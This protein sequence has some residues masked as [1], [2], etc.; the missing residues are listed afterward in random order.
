M[1]KMY[2]ETKQEVDV[3]A[4]NL[5][6]Y[7][8]VLE[9]E[10]VDRIIAEARDILKRLGFRLANA[11]AAALLASAGA[12]WE[13][14]RR[15]VYLNDRLLDDALQA[16]P[17]EI[18]LYDRSGQEAVLLGGERVCFDPGSAALNILD[19]DSR[20]VRPAVSR[21]TIRLTRLVDGLEHL[22]A[23]ST[24]L[25]CSDVPLKMQD[26]YRLYLALLYSAK[27]V[28]TGTFHKDSF[29]LMRH[30]LETV[31]GGGA[32]LAKKPLA[33]F[34]ACPSPP[35]TWSDLT[36]QS[37]LDAARAGIPSELVSMPLTGANAP[38]TLLGAVVQHTAES[39]SG[40][41]ISQLARPG[42]PLIWGGSPAAFDLRRGTTPMGSI[43]TML[44][45]LA[46][47]R[48]GKRL[49]LPTHAY[50]G[51]SDAKLLDAQAGLESAL[52]TVLAGLG[53][54]NMV[55]GA[56]MLNFESTQSLEKL[57]IDNEICGMTYKMLEGLKVRDTPL[58]GDLLT[59]LEAEGHLLTH[60]HTLRWMRE[61]HYAP[62]VVID[63]DNQQEW[64]AAGS[65][66]AGERAKRR[67][68]ELIARHPGITLAAEQ[69]AAL[70]ELMAAEGRR[71][72]L[73]ALPAREV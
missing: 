39:L 46:C 5:R 56:G 28:V 11:E 35:L 18:R 38:V 43:D 20:A 13:P 1:L 12:R 36:C 42:A 31:R 55:S 4:E 53:G 50:M 57:V 34:D 23:Q 59:D 72:G 65:L 30:M 6:P 60:P 45:D 71:H 2:N 7:L 54:I 9:T 8:V 44:I 16:A 63:R 70:E 73:E 37:L 41:V 47:A 49:G 67:V 19:F 10:T 62:G 27:P 61:E 66:S 52:G 25:I 40:L 24:A 69:A 17:G 32:A 58:A 26:S 68:E 22:H 33:V 48:V 21:D 14:D 15:R 3:M 29:T 51:L 64:A